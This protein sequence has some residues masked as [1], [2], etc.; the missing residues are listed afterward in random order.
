MTTNKNTARQNK[1]RAKQHEQNLQ[2]FERGD[3]E[4]KPLDEAARSGLF[5]FLNAAQKYVTRRRP[6]FVMYESTKLTQVIE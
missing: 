1:R 6:G 2:A 4:I 5:R 3:A